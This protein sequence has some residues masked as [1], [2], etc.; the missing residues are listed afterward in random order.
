[1]GGIVVYLHLGG[2][3]QQCFQLAVGVRTLPIEDIH[4]PHRCK[5]AHI[6]TSPIS[7]THHVMSKKGS[8]DMGVLFLASRDYPSSEH[9]PAE[10]CAFLPAANSFRPFHRVPVVGDPWWISAPSQLSPTH[11]SVSIYIYLCTSMRRK[12]FCTHMQKEDLSSPIFS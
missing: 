6:P 1:M 4:S 2:M 10:A 9:L 12:I 3:S 5:W 7:P 11:T 8:Q